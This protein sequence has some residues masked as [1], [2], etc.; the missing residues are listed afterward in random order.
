MP[1]FPARWLMLAGLILAL[2]GGALTALPSQAAVG[3]PVPQTRTFGADIEPLP[4]YQGQSLCDPIP[5]PGVVAVKKLLLATYGDHVI[6]IP[7]YGCHGIS[8]HHEGRALDWM[9][10]VRRADE[11]AQANAFI[12]WLL[13]KD[14]Q[15]NAYAMARR[16][17]VMYIIWNNKI[18][19]TYDPARG[20]TPYKTCASHPESG[21][22][23]T[24]HRDHVHISFTWDGAAAF[25]S[26]YTGK[27]LKPGGPCPA[28]GTAAAG[29]ASVVNQQFMPLPATTVI[30][31]ATGVGVSGSRPCRLEARLADPVTN[32]MAVEIAGHAGV[33]ASG[34][35]AV[36]LD[37]QLRSNAPTRV[38][39]G[40]SDDPPGLAM[41]SFVASGGTAQTQ[42]VV[43]LG[44]DGR[45]S[46]A[47]TFG[48]QWIRATVQGYF[49]P[50]GGLLLNPVEPR[51]V[52]S[53]RTIPAGEFVDLVVGGAAGVPRTGVGGLALVVRAQ[54]ATAG[55]S[56]SISAP[57]GPAPSGRSVLY[58][59]VRALSQPVWVPSSPTGVV[60]ITNEGSS[61]A[62]VVTTVAGWLGA[63][64][65]AFT[66][67]TGAL[68]ADTT[69]SRGLNAAVSAGASAPL[70]LAGSARIPSS[71]SAVWLQATAL[72]PTAGFTAAIHSRPLG[73]TT[74][75]QF[76]SLPTGEQTTAVLARLDGMG[77]VTVSGL[78]GSS[79][80]RLRAVGWWRPSR[81]AFTVSATASAPYAV[82]PA[83]VSLSGR[84]LLS[85]SPAARRLRVQRLDG[86][87]WSTVGTV[88][89]GADG[90]Y[91]AVLPAV[92]WGQR[93]YRVMRVDEGCVA[94][95]CTVKG[96]ASR[97][98]TV[99]TAEPFVVTATAPVMNRRDRSIPISG[100]VGPAAAPGSVVI[101]RRGASGWRY[102]AT[103]PVSSNGGFST[104]VR[105]STGTTGVVQ[106][107]VVRAAQQC[108]AGQCLLLAGSSRSF[109]V[110][111]V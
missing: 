69:T 63:T 20:W 27:A 38:Y 109:V 106:L 48:A 10:S 40:S 18:W 22:D 78:A 42:M 13:A 66:L 5:R 100:K 97:V 11:R 75:Q 60:R 51:A 65:S 35:T 110:R 67:G 17:G 30:D 41:A 104:K 71:A 55:G 46:V 76:T 44:S 19:R 111:L 108:V 77:R 92:G 54:G 62:T 89:S 80:L 79:D 99:R 49:L 14:G 74:G 58:S 70:P 24:C 23:T 47:S 98:I 53:A 105:L 16:M 6:Y 86:A 103:A 59:R 36:L 8:E 3:T 83:S 45:I 85:G 87:N 21:Y 26:F 72:N 84:L 81:P 31:T 9:V 82:A 39:V 73:R 37:L 43:P 50:I 2:T 56:L 34:A 95:G 93:S 25:T 64:G 68:V 91:R 32:L 1:R 102:L 96:G 101:Q 94:V 33:P 28:I 107:R 12:A 15:G 52:G 7:R 88:F 61:A 29:T 57:A 4:T 90:R